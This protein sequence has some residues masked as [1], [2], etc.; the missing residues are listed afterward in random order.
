[1]LHDYTKEDF[2]T[3]ESKLKEIIVISKRA[4]NRSKF[5]PENSNS[6][7]LYLSIQNFFYF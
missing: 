6:Y 1:M 7:G 5:K 2:E 4:N 3:I